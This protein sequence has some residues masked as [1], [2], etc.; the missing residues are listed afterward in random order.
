MNDHNKKGGLHSFTSFV[1]IDVYSKSQIKAVEEM[2]DGGSS[3]IK[4]NAN[5][6]GCQATS[7]VRL[8]RNNAA[9]TYRV[10]MVLN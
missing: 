1:C 6:S 4:S 10:T 9:V 8:G 2:S 5:I 3:N 7:N